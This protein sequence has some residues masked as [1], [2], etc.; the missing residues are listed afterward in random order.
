MTTTAADTMPETLDVVEGGRPRKPGKNQTRDRKDRTS[1]DR[2]SGNKNHGKDTSKDRSGGSKNGTDRKKSSGR[3]GKYK[4]AQWRRGVGPL[5]ADDRHLVSRFSF[6]VTTDLTRE[7]RK[8][9]NARRWFRAQLNPAAISDPVADQIATW[10]PSLAYDPA[11][12]WQ[13]NVDE[14]EGGW[15]A[16]SNYQSHLLCRRIYTRRQVLEVMTAFWEEHFHVPVNADGVFTW[17]AHYGRTIR[18]RALTTFPELL[19]AATTHPAMGMFLNN[20]EST[21]R[22]PNE[23]LG[24]ELMELHSVGRGNYTEDDVKAAARILTGWRV[25][26]WKTFAAEYKPGDHWTGPVTVM[27]FSDPNSDPNGQALT[28]RFTDY[29]ATHPATASRLSHKL[30]VKFVADTPPADLVAAMTDTWL[31]T[32][33]DVKSVLT[34]MVEHPKFYTGAGVKVRDPHEDVVATYRVLDVRPRRPQKAGQATDALLWQTS[35]IGHA[36]HSWPRPDGQPIDSRAWST[37][38]RLLASMQVH[39][40]LAG[41]WWPNERVDYRSPKKWLPRNDIRLDQYVDHLC[42]TILGV[43]STARHLEACCKAVGYKPSEAITK[44]HA[45]VAY[46]TPRLLAILLDSPDH[47]TR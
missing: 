37:P 12:L 7:V 21:K 26:M 31:R 46:E 8:A 44:K 2:P 24:R 5:P 3:R 40:S 42:R 25:D 45:I 14:V 30:A 19:Y 36:P 22:A 20:A 9:G 11:T 18:D 27:G 15:I 17:R 13:R 1:D 41:G 6:G 28:R 43:P 47:M 10:W 39:Y 4:P 16:M 23:N 32:A 29:L 35:Q 33:G 38:N 34:A